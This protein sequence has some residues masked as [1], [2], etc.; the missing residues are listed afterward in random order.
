[1]AAIAP[2]LTDGYLESEIATAGLKIQFNPDVIYRLNAAVM[3]GFKLVPRRGLE[4]GGL[5][6]GR[7]DAGTVVVDDFAPVASE[8]QHGPSWLLSEKDKEQLADA[9]SKA[10][11]PDKPTRVVGMYRSQTRA[12]FAPSEEDIAVFKEHGGSIF[13]LVKPEGIGRSSALFAAG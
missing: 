12:G 4:V 10:N 13:L 3:E 6:L 11:D 5:L 9:L 1:M 2:S 8:H 7:V